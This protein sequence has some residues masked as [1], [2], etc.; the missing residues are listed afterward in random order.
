MLDHRKTKVIPKK[1]YFCFIDYAKAFDC[2][3]HNKLWKNSL[4]HIDIYILYTY[5][6]QSFLI[7]F[8]NPQQFH[9]LMEGSM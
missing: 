4:K 7:L 6:L 8:A 1:I 9:K 2:V 5:S 3:D